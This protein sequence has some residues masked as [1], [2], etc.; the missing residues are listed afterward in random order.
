MAIEIPEIQLPSSFSSPPHAVEIEIESP[1]GTRHR[2]RVEGQDGQSCMDDVVH[3]LDSC[4]KKDLARR[5][6]E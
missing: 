1:S 2:V 3:L 6:A 4:C 5:L